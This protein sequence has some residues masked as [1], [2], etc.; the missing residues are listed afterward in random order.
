MHF[1]FIFEQME[2][3]NTEVRFVLFLS[4]TKLHICEII[5]VPRANMSQYDGN[6]KIRE[7]EREKCKVNACVK[8]NELDG[9]RFAKKNEIDDRRHSRK[10][11]D[12]PFYSMI[13]LNHEFHYDYFNF[14]PI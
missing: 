5:E 10:I 7:R 1:V 11:N 6:Y 13:C 9:V 2:K 8:I 3:K 4:T 12:Q 14:F